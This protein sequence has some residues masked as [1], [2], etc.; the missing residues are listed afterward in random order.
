M[1]NKESPLPLSS[2]VSFGD[3]V[4][5]AW[6]QDMDQ[7]AVLSSRS[8]KILTQG[9]HGLTKQDGELLL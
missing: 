3:P 2:G 4:I 6:S 5:P 1:V 8:S 9:G 7:V